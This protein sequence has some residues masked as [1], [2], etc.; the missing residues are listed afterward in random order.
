MKFIDT[1]VN[2]EERFSLG[3]E[4]TSGQFFASFPVFN[5]LIEYEGYYAIDQQMSER[6]HHDLPQRLN[7]STVAAGERWT[8]C[9]FKSQDQNEASLA[10]NAANPKFTAYSIGDQIARGLKI[11]LPDGQPLESLHRPSPQSQE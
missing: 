2:R 4:E 3:I 6:F 11:Q 10:S 5:G 9:C 7:S 1:Y 8:S